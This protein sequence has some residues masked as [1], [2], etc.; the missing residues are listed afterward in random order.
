M[1]TRDGKMYNLKNG[2]DAYEYAKTSKYG[3][4][5]LS[6]WD[7]QIKELKEEQKLEAK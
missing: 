2:K 5:I 4:I 1:I 3:K 7:K 6:Y